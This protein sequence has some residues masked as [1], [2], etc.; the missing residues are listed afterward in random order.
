MNEKKYMLDGVPISATGLI[1]EAGKLD[2]EFKREW[3]QTT[4]EAA[5][6]L[7]EHGYAVENRRPVN[8]SHNT[9]EPCPSCG[10][11]HASHWHGDGPPEIFCKECHFEWQGSPGNL[12]PED[13]AEEHRLN[14]Q[15]LEEEVTA[16]QGLR[17]EAIAYRGEEWWDN[18]EKLAA[19]IDAAYDESQI[20]GIEKRRQ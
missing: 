11:A 6:I 2:K 16:H 3:L 18:A 8:V 17:E 19:A 4:S 1:L 14:R 5:K 7:R 20:R 10:Y 15:A 13:E 9:L 12:S